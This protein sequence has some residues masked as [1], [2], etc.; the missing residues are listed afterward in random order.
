MNAQFL[1][2]LMML[3]TENWL[4]AVTAVWK[5]LDSHLP[6]ADSHLPLLLLGLSISFCFL[7]P[8]PPPE[9]PKSCQENASSVVI[10]QQTGQPE[11]QRMLFST[12]P[13]NR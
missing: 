11:N 2:W 8:E 6:A 13:G 10:C 4:P 9:L 3:S 1:A 12:T 7:H 5:W